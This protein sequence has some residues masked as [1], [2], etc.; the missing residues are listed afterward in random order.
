MSDVHII[1]KCTKP[2]SQTLVKFYEQLRTQ[3]AHSKRCDLGKL[4]FDRHAH[5]GVSRQLRRHRIQDTT[6]I[7]GKYVKTVPHIT[8]DIMN[9]ESDADLIPA[10][11]AETQFLHRMPSF[12][13]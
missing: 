1:W 2:K 3:A 7:E 4:S 9:S 5:C 13:F 10:H 8:G 6:R 12:K 11:W